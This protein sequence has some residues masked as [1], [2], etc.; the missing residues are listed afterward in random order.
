MRSGQREGCGVHGGRVARPALS[1]ALSWSL[2]PF[3]PPSCLWRSCVRPASWGRRPCRRSCDPSPLP[4]RTLW[5]WPRQGR[6]RHW[7]SCCRPSCTC[8]SVESIRGG[9]PRCWSL[10]PRTSWPTHIQEGAAKLGRP[11]QQHGELTA[12]SAALSQGLPGALSRS[13]TCR[14]DDPRLSGG[15]CTHGC[16]VEIAAMQSKPEVQALVA[17][18]YDGVCVL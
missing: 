12:L 18:S 10:R 15:H 7:A 3:C 1:S 6:Q 8:S 16:A 13:G 17:V 9:G 4:A 14:V 2:V 5:L 11:H